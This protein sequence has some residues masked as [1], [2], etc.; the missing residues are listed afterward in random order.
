[1]KKIPK[2]L[3]DLEKR[4]AEFKSKDVVQKQN[5]PLTNSRLFAKA[6]VLGTEFVGAVLVGVGL[7]L[8]LDR[9]LN[10]K[11]IFTIIFTLF[12]CAAGILNMYRSTKEME[13]ELK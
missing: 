3:N 4:I 8:L 2:D 10:S 9:L 6:F 12:G 1:M 7:G 13:K 5:E 11:V